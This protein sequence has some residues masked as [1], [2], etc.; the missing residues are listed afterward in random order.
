M[1]SMYLSGLI[2]IASL[3]A[4]CEANVLECEARW[5]MSKKLPRKRKKVERNKILI[6]Y[7]IFNHG[8]QLFNF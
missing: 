6:D 1:K 8:V 4:M 7:T 5:E 3:S 2:E